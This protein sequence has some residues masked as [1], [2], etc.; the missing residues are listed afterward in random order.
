MK[1]L[2]IS[3]LFVMQVVFVFAQSSTGFIGKVLD[4]RT[5][6]PLQN[7]V[8]SIQ[9]TNL[10]ALSDASGVFTFKEVAP[11]SQ[12]LQIRNTGYKDQ[13]LSVDVVSGKILDLGIIILEEDISVDQQIALVAITDNDLGDDNSGSESTSSLLQAS[14]DAF[15]QSAAFNWGQARFRIRGLDSQYGTTMINGIVMNKIYDGRPQFSNWGGLNDATRNQEFTT[16]IGPSDYSFGG[17]LGTNEINTRASIYR[18]GN[19]ISAGVTNTNYTG[20]LMGTVASGMRRDGWAYVVSASRRFTDDGYFEGTTYNANSFFASVEKKLSEKHSLNFTSIVGQN[21]RGKNSPNTQ[22]VNDLKSET[23]NSYWGYQNGRKRNS[24]IRNIEEPILI[25]SHYWK[26]T[27]K[28]NLNT[29]V[30]YQFGKI[31][32][33][34]LT[35]QGADNPDPTYYKNLPSYET[36]LYDTNGNYTPDFTEAG[37]KKAAFLADGQLNWDGLVYANQHS[38]DGHSYYTLYEDRTDDKQF[39]ANTIL[40]TQLSDHIVLNAGATYRNLNSHNYQKMIDLLGGSYFKDVTLFGVGYNQQQSD[41]N[42]PGRIVGVGDAFGYNY[43]LTS[44]NIDAFTQFKF[45]Y[46]KVDFF[47][48]QNYSRSEYQREGLFKNGYY[49]TNS[50]GKSSKMTFDNFGFKGGITYKITGKQFLM[51]NAGYMTLAPNLRNVFNNARINNNTVSGL[52]NENVS[53]ADVSY[54]INSPKLKTRLT[55]YYTSIKN[56]TET[57]FFFGDGVSVDDPSTSIIEQSAFVAET[58]T[59]INKRNI[60]LEFG[61]EYPITSSLKLTASGAYGEYIYDNNPN[62][63]LN[64]DARATATNT[65]PVINY[66]EAKLKN[67]RQSGMPQ[68]AASLGLEYRDPKFWSIGANVNYLANNYIDVAPITR[69]ASFYDDVT[70]APGVPVPGASEAIGAALLKQEKFNDFTLL[71]LNG[72]KSWKINKST[73]GFNASISNVLNVKYKTGGFEQARNS[74]Y[75]QSLQDNTPHI[76]P[77]NVAAGAVAT[78]AFAPKYF[79][80]YGRTFFLNLYINF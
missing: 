66:G 17:I 34:R 63:S 10:T 18:P 16:G 33:S 12:L 25:L 37:L 9:N 1:K 44:N 59:N 7:V 58:V 49:P 24:R 61:A 2:V 74:N 62:V 8:A 71:N 73:F 46:K 52:T 64:V 26:V 42:N 22:E 53:T 4:T 31:G 79:Y 67:Y 13:L 30:S 68:T 38:I 65:S 50:F 56:Q 69:T 80:G 72:S 32:N 35:F 40:N 78:P 19:R 3:T 36:S 77:N 6:K 75:T 15:Q 14:R 27:S 39:T 29:N 11:G 76:N 23:Y 70:V 21:N 5:Q 48:A 47:L 28:T 60:G 45:V 20:R 43:N 54:V 57:S 55:A 41:L 51:L